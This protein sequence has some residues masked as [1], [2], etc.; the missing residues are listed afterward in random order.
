VQ[1]ELRQEPAPILG[2]ARQQSLIAW[3]RRG[4]QV[5]TTSSAAEARA[6]IDL[7]KP[8]VI[9]S[10]IGMPGEDGLS[11]IRALRGHPA[12]RDIPAIA[13]TAYTTATDQAEAIKAGYR[14]HV[15]KPVPPYR[16]ARV[17][18]TALQ[19]PS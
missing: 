8:D 16:L 11:F 1:G 7:R 13:L 19:R 6:E 5:V 15:P 4:G 18:V 10:D 17:I 12:H 3:P 2:E 14:E 9:V